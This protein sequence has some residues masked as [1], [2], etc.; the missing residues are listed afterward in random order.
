MIGG[1]SFVKDVAAGQSV[2]SSSPETER[3]K[4]PVRP[5]AR[6]NFVGRQHQTK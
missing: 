5:A 4:L 1:A 6:G 3:G 2:H